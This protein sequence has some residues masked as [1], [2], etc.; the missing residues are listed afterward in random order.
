MQTLGS[1]QT[2]TISERVWPWN[3][4]IS[5]GLPHYPYAQQ[6]WHKVQCFS[7]IFDQ[8][9]KQTRVRS[10]AFVA[11]RHIHMYI[12]LKLKK[13]ILATTFPYYVGDILICS[14]LVHSVLLH[15]I[16]TR[17]LVVTH[18]PSHRFLSSSLKNRQRCSNNV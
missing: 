18:C 12:K 4:P 9:P 2:G 8:E 17:R 16:Q 1:P 10:T 5:P 14:T 15:S 3:H 6:D 13:K 7:N 11:T